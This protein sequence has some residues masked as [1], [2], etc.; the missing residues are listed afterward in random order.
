VSLIACTLVRSILYLQYNSTT[1]PF[2]VRNRTIQ[3][4]IQ[5]KHKPNTKTNYTQ[6]NYTTSS[7]V[8]LYRDNMKFLTDLHNCSYLPLWDFICSHGGFMF[9]YPAIFGPTPLFSIVPM[10]AEY[11]VCQ[12]ISSTSL[13]FVIKAPDVFHISLVTLSDH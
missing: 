6:S 12:M 8:K 2:T 3:I 1:F 4:W 5:I 7:I 10:I 9:R 13:L 11:Q